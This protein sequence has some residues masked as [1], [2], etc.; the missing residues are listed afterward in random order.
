MTTRFFGMAHK[1]LDKSYGFSPT[2][3]K[4]LYERF[5][6]LNICKFTAK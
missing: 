2:A 1:G 4:L 6:A 5:M 3:P